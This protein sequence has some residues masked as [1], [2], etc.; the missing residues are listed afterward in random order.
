MAHFAEINSQNL[1]LRILVVPDE[2]QHRG[3][4]FLASDLKLGGT[5]IQT[6]YNGNIR[7]NYAGIDYTYDSQRDAFIPKKPFDSWVLDEETCNWFPPIPYP[8]DGKKYNWNEST[9]NWTEIQ[10]T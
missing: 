10:S 2:E 8:Q 3:Q 1:V 6:S 5:W 4:E 7:K 9:I